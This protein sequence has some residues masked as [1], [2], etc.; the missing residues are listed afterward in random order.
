MYFST[1]QYA[2]MNKHLKIDLFILTCQM[3]VGCCD[4]FICKHPKAKVG[5]Q[6]ENV[7][8]FFIFFSIELE[9]RGDK[10]LFKLLK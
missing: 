4:L 10:V 5:F 7:V 3:K 8:F 1:C 9:Y 6:L 2:K